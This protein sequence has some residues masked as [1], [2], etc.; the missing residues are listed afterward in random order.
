M[1]PTIP[2]G[3]DEC[4]IAWYVTSL[5]S[6]STAYALFQM[7]WTENYSYTP[8]TVLQAMEQAKIGFCRHYTFTSFTNWFFF[9]QS[10]AVSYKQAAGNRAKHRARVTND[11]STSCRAGKSLATS[12][13]SRVWCKQPRVG[14]LQNW[15][16][17]SMQLSTVLAGNTSSDQH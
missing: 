1:S 8:P 17:I 3:M 16:N 6:C 4:L 15:P 2:W 12:G 7:L 9:Y 11:A 13:L 14:W 10:Q 5:V